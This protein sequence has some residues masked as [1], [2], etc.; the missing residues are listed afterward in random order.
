MVF[1]IQHEHARKLCTASSILLSGEERKFT[2]TEV[3]DIRLPTHGE[4]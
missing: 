3:F 4:I 2:E 1:D